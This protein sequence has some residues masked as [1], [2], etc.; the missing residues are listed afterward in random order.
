M[1]PGVVQRNDAKMM[2]VK[3]C[4]P[5]VHGYEDKIG[6]EQRLISVLLRIRDF[7]IANTELHQHKSLGTLY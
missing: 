3:S 4:S 1:A 6:T 2:L 7:L 5:I